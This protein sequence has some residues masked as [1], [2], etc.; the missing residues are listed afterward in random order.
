MH[1]GGAKASL[2]T[3]FLAA[4]STDGVTFRNIC[5]SV[6][7]YYTVTGGVRDPI[8]MYRLG[9]W[10]MVHSYGGQVSPHVLLA[11]SDNLLQW[12]PIGSLRL[13]AD[14]GRNYVD[15]PQWIVDPEDRVHS[16]ACVDEDHYYVETH[17]LSDDP[18]TWGDQ[19]N[20]SAVTPVTDHN[21]EVLVQGNSHVALRDGTYYMVL[22][23]VKCSVYYMRTSADLV[24]GWSAP[25]QLDLDRMVNCGD[26]LNL[27]FLSDGSLRFYISNGNFRRYVMWCVDSPDLG[28]TWTSPTV[29]QFEGFSPPGI[30]WAEVVRITDPA[31]IAGMVAAD[32]VPI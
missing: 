23:D 25:R 26:S 22:N 6:D 30:N 1:S 3:A 17:P 9:Q 31:A 19:A 11:K 16:I 21:G 24:S 18:A 20:W 29:L 5:G 8:V 15:V 28:F 2:D 14:K 12:T 4:S 13:A 10:Y 32:Q 7:P 27:I